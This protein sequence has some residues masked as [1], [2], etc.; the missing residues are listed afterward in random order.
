MN[1]RI[2][3]FSFGH[4]FPEHYPTPPD[5]KTSQLVFDVRMSIP[6]PWNNGHKK[7]GLYFETSNYVIKNGEEFIIKT[8]KV[9]VDIVGDFLSEEQKD[10]ETL[11]IFFGC[12]GGWQR[13]VAL[14]EN[15]HAFIKKMH[16]S[17]KNLETMVKHLSI[18]RW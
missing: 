2:E 18:D 6:D 17:D 10:F 5:E 16:E 8:K 4:V 3:F 11:K 13:S 1:K 14:A 9:I 7:N 15:F 12:K